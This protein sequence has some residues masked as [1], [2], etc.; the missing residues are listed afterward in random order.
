VQGFKELGGMQDT[1]AQKQHVYAR[2]FLFAIRQQ[3]RCKK[4]LFC[5][6]ELKQQQCKAKRNIKI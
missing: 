6:C 2:R 5:F 3:S 4:T 1:L